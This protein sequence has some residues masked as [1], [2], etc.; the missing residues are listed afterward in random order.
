VGRVIDQV[1]AE[2]NAIP[3]TEG[4]VVQT[5]GLFRYVWPR[6]DLLAVATVRFGR[7]LL[8]RWAGKESTHLKEP[9]RTWLS[10]QW[11]KRSLDVP[12]VIERLNQSVKD[13]VREDPDVV[14]EAIVSP[15]T[16][17]T[18]GAPRLDAHAAVLVL[19]Q[20]LK[21]V[22]KPPSE[23]DKSGTLYAIL[24]E[25]GKQHVPEYNSKLEAALDSRVRVQSLTPTALARL[26]SESPEDLVKAR[27]L[28]PRAEV[29]TCCTL[30]L[31]PSSPVTASPILLQ[32]QVCR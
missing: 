2:A 8:Q 30:C 17:R 12:D 3:R 31:M 20:L 7:M 27:S 15:L 16:D 11:A 22:G 18:S 9:F 4:P 28:A 26:A 23:N 6:T 29:P 21:L 5:F 10:E 25:F 24:D 19:D 13:A 1:R 14:F 32:W